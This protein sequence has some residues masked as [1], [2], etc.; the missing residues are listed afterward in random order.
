MFTHDPR[1]GR[2]FRMVKLYSAERTP[3]TQTPRVKHRAKTPSLA[4]MK[5]LLNR[6]KDFLFREV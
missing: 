2:H 6:V 5:K 3:V 1:Y 4:L